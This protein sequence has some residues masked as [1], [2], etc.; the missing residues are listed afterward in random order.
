VVVLMRASFI[1]ALDGF[2]DC[3]LRNFQFLKFW[4]SCFKVM[5]DCCFS[6]SSWVA[7]WSKALHQAV[8]QPAVIGSPKVQRAIVP[9]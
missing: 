1:I 5:M 9:V 2:C 7:Q 3:T 8:S 6:L 4:P